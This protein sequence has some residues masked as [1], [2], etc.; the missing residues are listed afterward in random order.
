[1]SPSTGPRKADTEPTNTAATPAA[2]EQFF[3]ALTSRT[4][5]DTHLRLLK[6]ALS[7]D[8][9]TALE[10]ELTKIVEELLHET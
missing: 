5:E 2:L 4:S 10:R 6:A 1:M 3:E 9:A 8:P 7:S